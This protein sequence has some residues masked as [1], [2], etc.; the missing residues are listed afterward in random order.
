[1]R[2]DCNGG[3]SGWRARGA[4]LGTCAVLCLAACP[5]PGPGRGPEGSTA[6][7]VRKDPTVKLRKFD[8]RRGVFRIHNDT[9]HTIRRVAVAIRGVRCQGPRATRTE[10][11][12]FDLRLRPGKS[13][14]FAFRFEHR[15]R[16]AHVAAAVQ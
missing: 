9:R 7:S 2:G 13:Q 8:G 3:Q 6:R 12:I 10:V 14:S 1:M 5:S 16:R 11:K 4:V 15:C